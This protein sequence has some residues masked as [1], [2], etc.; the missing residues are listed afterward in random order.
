MTEKNIYNTPQLLENREYFQRGKSKLRLSLLQDQTDCVEERSVTD[1][2]QPELR[3][4]QTENPANS[5]ITKPQP[6]AAIPQEEAAIDIEDDLSTQYSQESEYLNEE[7]DN[8]DGGNQDQPEFEILPDVEEK[9]PTDMAGRSILDDPDLI[10][11]G[12]ER[13]TTKYGLRQKPLRNRKY[14]DTE[15]IIPD[16]SIK[17]PGGNSYE[18]NTI[19]A[20]PKPNL[21]PILPKGILKIKTNKGSLNH[22][23]EISFF[24]NFSK[25]AKKAIREALYCKNSSKL[26]PQTKS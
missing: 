26:P 7:Q 9:Y 8:Q 4:A 2:H 15:I 17:P 25:P 21:N 3:L 19:R 10:D 13:T 5:V 24:E 1:W 16:D 14:F 22:S 18:I 6:Q 23:L 11:L 12:R 20:I